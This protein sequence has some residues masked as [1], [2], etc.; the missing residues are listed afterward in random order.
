MGQVGLDWLFARVSPEPP[1]YDWRSS[2]AE[3]TEGDA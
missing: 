1:K 2:S 3:A